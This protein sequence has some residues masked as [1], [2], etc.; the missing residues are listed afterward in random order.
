MEK[1][2][3]EIDVLKLRGNE[4]ERVRDLVIVEVPL[5]IF[6]NGEELITISHIPLKSE[7]LAVGFLLSEG[8][9]K[10]K[11]DIKS[12]NFY[13]DVGIVNITTSKN[14]YLLQDC[15]RIAPFLHAGGMNINNIRD[16]KDI[17]KVESNKSFSKEEITKLMEEM[18]L[19]SS[20][21]NETGGVHCS[22]LCKEGEIVCFAED[23][24]RHNT[25]D[26]IFGECLLSDIPIDGALILTSGRATSGIVAKA[27]KRGIPVLASRSAPTSLS[28]KIAGELGITLVGFVRNRRMNVYAGEW[29]IKQEEANAN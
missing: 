2:T 19:M 3:R 20:L 13:E 12:L 28:I 24:A 1:L 29:R 18:T 16:V 27:A 6:L 5:R 11:E 25:L 22:A 7:A 17:G 9:V 10:S 14:N 23:V 15:Q 21:F 4:R 26:K 8:L